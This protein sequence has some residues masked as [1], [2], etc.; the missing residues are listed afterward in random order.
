ML[1]RKGD[2]FVV[3]ALNTLPALA[4]KIF[5]HARAIRAPSILVTDLAAPGL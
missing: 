4:P 2:A 1:A 3:F 5:A